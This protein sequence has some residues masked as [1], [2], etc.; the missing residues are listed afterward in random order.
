MNVVDQDGFPLTAGQLQHYHMMKGNPELRTA[1]WSSYRISGALVIDRFIDSVDVLVARHEALRTEIVQEPGGKVRQRVVGPPDRARL[2]TCERVLSR[3]EDQ[4]NRYIR[5]LVASEQTKGWDAGAL[6]FRFRLFQYAP[7][8]HAFVAGFSHI[9]VDG[10][11]NEI[12]MR[13]LMSI[14]REA[15]RGHVPSGPP[16]QRFVES[17]V[18]QAAALERRTR[19]AK[20]YDLSGVPP[21]TQFQTGSL[22][23]RVDT[24]TLSRNSRFSLADEELAALRQL[25]DQHGCTEFHWILAAFAMTIFQ[26]TQQDRLK[27]SIPVN[28][29]SAADRDV[30]GMYVVA[31]PVVINRPAD[32]DHVRRYPREVG[33]AMLRAT[34]MYQMD[35]PELLDESLAAQSE[36][37]GARCLHDLTINYRKMLRVS[38]RS[39][40]QMDW[41][42]YQAQI[43]YSFPGVGLRILS[44]GDALDVH[45]VLNSRVFSDDTASGLV[46]ALRENLTSPDCWTKRRT[47][48]V[49]GEV[50]AL[51][52]ASGSTVVSANVG[53]V[54]EALLRHPLVRTASVFRET[55]RSGETYLC[56]DVGVRE[57]MTEDS[58]RE[59]LL[60]LGAHSSEVL[61]PSRIS[62]S[63]ATS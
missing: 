8:V 62:A 63:P 21:V 33:T 60:E 38:R 44:F 22:G 23:P 6:P 25:A 14:Y 24:G 18:R 11:G 27:I 54:E 46:E 41:S 51:K 36:G 58:L 4:F 17:A 35:S 37:W 10:V 29:R 50:V 49:P 9:A 20:A 30:V 53:K 26:F 47:Q 52:D 3:S 57:G 31:V 5:H 12:L 61:A 55:G 48:A 56:A 42:E 7:T 39:F 45:A 16:R 43:D 34:A 2:L 19:R 40:A 59:Y 32:L 28:L 13:D 1:I 15:M